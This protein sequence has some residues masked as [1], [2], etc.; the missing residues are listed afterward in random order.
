MS[1]AKYSIGIKQILFITTTHKQLYKLGGKKVCKA[2]ESPQNR[3]TAG[4]M[5][6]IDAH[7]KYKGKKQRKPASET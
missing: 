7:K 4:S 2:N 1:N 5:Q 6:C 3:Q